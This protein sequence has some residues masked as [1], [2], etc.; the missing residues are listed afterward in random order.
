MNF[1]MY[2]RY[3]AVIHKYP[4]SQ[5]DEENLAFSGSITVIV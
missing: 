5:L 3:T 2:H 4:N 1:T